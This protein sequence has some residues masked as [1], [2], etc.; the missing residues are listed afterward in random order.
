MKPPGVIL[1]GGAGRRIGGA[2][3]FVSLA[4]R[5]LWDHVAKRVAPQVSRLAGN[6]T[7]PM[8]DLPM[9]PD[10]PD[11]AGQGPLSGI[12][13]A[14]SWAKGQGADRVVTVAVDT[15]FLPLDLVD[16]LRVKTAPIVMAE[17]SDG[18]HGTTAI[19][20]VA[21]ADDL[22]QQ[23]TSGTRKVMDWAER[24]GAVSVRFPDSTPPPFFNINTEADLAQ[25]EA[26]A[27]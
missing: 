20:D 14:L 8:D 19:W 12:L 9:V 24:H 10:L 5:P 21:L 2:K 16:R 27:T 15:P 1:A 26:W 22:S 7:D 25:A 17:T 4:G 18:R 3:P 13:A 6:G 11:F 23:L